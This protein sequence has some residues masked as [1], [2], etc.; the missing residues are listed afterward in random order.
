MPPILIYLTRK[1]TTW[2]NFNIPV[3]KQPFPV[4]VLA[5]EKLFQK[6][7]SQWCNAA[8]SNPT[9][10][11]DYRKYSILYESR[12]KRIRCAYVLLNIFAYICNEC[13]N[14]ICWILCKDPSLVKV[15]SSMYIVGHFT[16][17][18]EGNTEEEN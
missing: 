5:S 15:W 4:N 3:R 16:R 12:L 2:A 11:V 17:E 1:H 10:Y 14:C 13:Y 18:H 9:E 7:W 8:Y 6:S